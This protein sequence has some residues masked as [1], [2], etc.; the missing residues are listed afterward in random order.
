MT[1]AEQ[2]PPGIARG[3][4]GTASFGGVDLAAL[5]QAYGTPLLAFDGELFD[6]SVAAFRSAFGPQTDISYAAKAF[7]CIALARRVASR[8]LTLDVCSL[9]ELRTA[10]AAAFPADGLRFHG[11]GKYDAELEAALAA[12]VGRIVVDNEEELERVECA[13]ARLR[14][15]APILLRVNTGI[16]AHTH[17]MVRTAGESSKFGMLPPRALAAALR[18][19]ASGN[20]HVHGLHSHIGSQIY[21]PR[22]FSDALEPLFELAAALHGEGVAVSELVAGGGFAVRYAPDHEAPPSPADLAGRLLAALQTGARSAGVPVPQLGIEPGRAL[23]GE[24]GLSLYRV[25]SVKNHGSKRFAIVDGSI[26]DNPRPALYGSY[27]HAL[28]AGRRSA[29][30][31]RETTVCGRSCEADLLVTCPLAEDLQ[32]GDLL[33][34]CTTGAYTYSMASNYNRFAKPPVVLVESGRHHLWVRRE[35][36]DETL[37]YDVDT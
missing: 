10:Q 3:A 4:A 30:R 23:V 14:R 2:L 1:I 15:R 29:A 12:G 37:R 17:E 22:F 24:A 27:H 26:A 35:R 34:I 8:G 20:L 7:L 28:L 19:A 11:C 33:A 13:A 6:Q 25:L 5:A 31:E 18:A 16:E 21:E 36:D 32:A 9:G